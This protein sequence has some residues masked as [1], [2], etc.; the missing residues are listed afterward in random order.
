MGRCVKHGLAASTGW[1][2]VARALVG[3]AIPQYSVDERCGAPDS[4]IHS[5]RAE[6]AV[7][8]ACTALHASVAVGHNRLRAIHRKHPV[9]AHFSAPPTSP[10]F[11]RVIRKSRHFAHVSH[12]SPHVW[13]LYAT[14]R[15]ADVAVAPMYKGSASRNSRLTPDLLVKVVQPVKFNARYELST[16]KNR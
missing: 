3:V 11:R 9:R 15:R 16:G 4:G 8:G 10:A 6:R 7:Q 5:N 12:M 13:S 14:R 1:P 2:A